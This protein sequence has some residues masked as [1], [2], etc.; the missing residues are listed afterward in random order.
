MLRLLQGKGI[1][2]AGQQGGVA[3]GKLAEIGV[4]LPAVIGGEVIQKVQCGVTGQ[5]HAHAGEIVKRVRADAVVNAVLIA[6]FQLACHVGGKLP[7]GI[8]EGCEIYLVG[9]GI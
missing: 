5:H 7:G 3:I 2:S 8:Q 9:G 1:V 4:L 6:F